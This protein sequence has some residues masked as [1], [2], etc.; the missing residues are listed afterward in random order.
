MPIRVALVGAGIFIKDA[1]LPALFALPHL[2]EVVAVYSRTIESA[3]AVAARWPT[4]P[5]VTQDL[6]ALLA[7]PDIDAVVIALPIHAQAEAVE[8]ALR[9]DKHVLSEKPIAATTRQAHALLD[10]YALRPDSAQQWLVAENWRY[11][12]TILRAAEII[13]SGVMGHLA[14]FHWGIYAGMTP[15]KP[16]YQTPW[17]RNGSHDGGF[18]LDGGIHFIAG[19]RMMLGDPLHFHAFGRQ[20]RPDLPPLDT[21]TATFTMANGLLGT[22]AITYAY[23]TPWPTS[24]TLVGEH[25]TLEVNR[26]SL[27]LTIHGQVQEQLTGQANGLQAEWEAFAHAITHH[28][29]PLPSLHQTLQDLT[30]MEA[31]LASIQ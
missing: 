8:L 24:L 12:P 26:D 16:Y 21:L 5:E 13:Q 30:L 19:L 14:M 4:P 22:V 7:R 6:P 25:G 3:K 1:H 31:L 29:D 17:R 28:T 15:D 27:K 20:T 2:F 18:I 9:A 23:A 10:L 11:A